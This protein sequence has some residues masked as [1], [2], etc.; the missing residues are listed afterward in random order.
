MSVPFDVFIR[1]WE[2]TT[3]TTFSLSDGTDGYK[4]RE[5]TPSFDGSLD[6]ITLSV[7]GDTVSELNTALSQLDDLQA[8]TNTSRKLPG[9]AS[10]VQLL[11][12]RDGSSELFYC[13]VYGL[14][15]EVKEDFGYP[16]ITPGNYIRNATLAIEHSVW[17]SF[18]EIQLTLENLPALG[19]AVNIEDVYAVSADGSFPARPREI[20]ISAY[21]GGPL[22]ELW[23]GFISRSV[24]GYSLDFEPNWQW[25]DG[26][27]LDADTTIT[28]VGT[29]TF[30]ADTT[31]IDRA[32]ITD[33]SFM[34]AAQ[35]WN[36]RGNFIVLL[37]AR[38][39]G[40][41][42]YQVE[43][44]CG[45]SGGDYITRGG[46][47][48]VSGTSNLIYEAGEVTLPFQP[49]AEEATVS[50]E[51]TSFTL[52]AGVLVTGTGNLE[53][54]RI[55]L[56]PKGE[57]FLHVSGMQMTAGSSGQTR[58]KT[59]ALGSVRTYSIND[60]SQGI[61]SPATWTGGIP[62]GQAVFI[63]AAQRSTQS[64]STDTVNL[65]WNIRERWRWPKGLLV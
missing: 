6:T 42:T 44:K 2:G 52:A 33:S 17:E 27:A 30:S 63:L 53:F 38:A 22:S 49:L 4:I 1:H 37:R 32:R 12:Q 40:T 18:T 13:L 31:L 9:A 60:S 28:T 39:T 43:I 48:K 21:T 23:A 10:F 36:L 24:V 55:I 11:V 45:K 25:Q 20:I 35:I 64:V 7:F 62:L 47:F 54:E 19:G 8:A 46:R 34:S 16:S 5:W 57:G 50:V 61:V 51:P 58:V 56:I 14:R 26:S 15:F 41:R 65:T 29:T 59:D 3:L